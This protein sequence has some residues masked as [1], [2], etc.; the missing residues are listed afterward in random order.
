[1]ISESLDSEQEIVFRFIV[2]RRIFTLRIYKP[3]DDTVITGRDKEIISL[4]IL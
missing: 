4:G 3:A 1:M 2:N